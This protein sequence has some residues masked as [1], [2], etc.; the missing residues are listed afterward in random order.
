M[1][2][3]T[4]RVYRDGVELPADP[5]TDPVDQLAD[6]AT[7]VWIDL[8]DAGDRLEA[9]GEK[10]GLHPLAVEDALS[11]HNRDKWVQ[12]PNH[13]FLVVHAADLDTATGTLE[14]C[15]IDVFVGPRW[16]VTVHEGAGALMRKVAE[17]PDRPH[18]LAAAGSGY[19]LY[20]LLD[21]IVNGYADVL[22]RFEAYYDEVAD[23]VF[24][25]KPIRGAHQR[26]FAMRRALIRFDR[27]L[28]PLHDGIGP[29]MR[30]DVDRFAP[31]AAPYLRDVEAEVRRSALE[32]DALRELVG[33]ITDT[34]VALR[35]LNQSAV[36]KRVTSWAAIIAV[37]TLVTSWY[38]M[39]VPY[40][41]EHQTWGVVAA[42]VLSVGIA[43]ILYVLFRRAD[44]L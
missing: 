7:M 39:N 16:L 24:A 3:V 31:A 10:L 19:L 25:D 44:W 6:T 42:A 29:L 40:P 23:Q 1:S 37:P 15:E 18:D 35:E 28:T 27:I 13:V 34:E 8:D 17:R 2:G 14:T 20:R 12:H 41:G 21:E 4:C 22:D 43:G 33:Q 30:E 32:V 11:E 38:G 9:L 26:W 36:M 5:D